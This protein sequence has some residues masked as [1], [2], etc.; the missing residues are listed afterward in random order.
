MIIFYA[1]PAAVALAV[2]AYTCT[3]GVT[4][5]DGTIPL[6]GEWRIRW[7]CWRY[8]A[9]YRT[10]DEGEWMHA[11]SDRNAERAA[12]AAIA[13]LLMA[14]GPASDADGTGRVQITHARVVSQEVAGAGNVE[15]SGP[16]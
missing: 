7:A 16:P 13:K 11:G 4:V 5:K 1:I 14:A 2:G 3:K 9:E 8:L 15:G 6:R 12:A 10:D